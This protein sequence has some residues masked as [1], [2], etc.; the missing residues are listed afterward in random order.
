[1]ARHTLPDSI[2]GPGPH[3][4]RVSAPVRPLAL[5]LVL[6]L[7]PAQWTKNLI[8]FAALLF[9]QRLQDVHAV[10]YA[11]AAFGVFCL[12]SGVVYLLNDVAD[13]ETDR[14]HPVKR[15]RPIASG[16]LPVGVAL[17]SA[18]ALAV[19]ALGTAF[20]LRPAFG[21]VGALYLALLA[22]YS[23]PLKHVVIIDVLTIAAGFVLRAEADYYS[24]S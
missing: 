3:G 15:R 10:L 16:A 1:M 6:S 20:W 8:I 5:N 7:R 2:E 19:V 12:L 11:V 18:A 13:R 14:S 17:A 22:S 4:E 23:G 21:V 24:Q 9:G